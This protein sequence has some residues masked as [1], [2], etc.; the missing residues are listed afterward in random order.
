MLV[1]SLS[2]DNQLYFWD[3][4]TEYEVGK[5]AMCENEFVLPIWNF[6][7]SQLDNMNQKYQDT[8][9]DRNKINGSKGGRPPKTEQ[10][11]QDIANPKNPMGL[12]ETQKTL[13]KNNNENNNINENNILLK[14]ETKSK[15]EKVIKIKFEESEIFDVY[16]FA[17]KFN[18]WN[19][20]KLKYYFDSAVSYSKEGNKYVD[21][22]AAISNWAA[23]DELAG[24]LK[25]DTVVGQNDSG[26]KP[27]PPPETIKYPKQK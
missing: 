15:K 27:A 21:W 5:E 26:Y 1:K 11:Q 9:V 2:K 20:I 3:L 18:T 6:I 16:K 17:A 10:T 24:K 13:N 22:A 12:N 23:R 8:I 25:F 7:K 4:F 14:K 19:K